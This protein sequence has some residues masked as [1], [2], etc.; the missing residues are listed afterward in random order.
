M[1]VLRFCAWWVVRA[2]IEPARTQ[3]LRA[4]TCV[5][6]VC[7]RCGGS[8]VRAC[9]YVNGVERGVAHGRGGGGGG[10]GQQR[11]DAPIMQREAVEMLA[12]GPGWPVQTKAH[13]C[14]GPWPAVAGPRSGPQQTIA[15]AAKE[16]AAGPPAAAPPRS[17]A[18]A[19]RHSA[20]SAA[21]PAPRRGGG[22]AGQG[23][24][25]WRRGGCGGGGGGQRGQ[26]AAAI[27]RLPSQG[28]PLPARPPPPHTHTRKHAA[29]PSPAAAS[30]TCT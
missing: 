8:C 19:G 1:R 23:W 16:V 5:F 4:R 25:G 15:K 30:P 14:S 9:M 2:C 10:G 6:L 29:P 13:G 18:P 3:V 27:T 17:P 22:G 12:D 20:G 28:P 26:E 11:S 24:G 21:A 7:A